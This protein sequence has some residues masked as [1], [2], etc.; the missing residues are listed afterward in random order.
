M[1]HN[2]LNRIWFQCSLMFSRLFGYH[3][4]TA[5]FL[6][7]FH[8]PRERASFFQNVK[9]RADSYVEAACRLVEYSEEEGIDILTPPQLIKIKFEH[10][11]QTNSFIQSDGR[12]Y[13]DPET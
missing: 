10:L 3:G 13:F 1:R 9:V 7:E 8:S 11:Q 12:I 2:I 5:H 6:V 4:V